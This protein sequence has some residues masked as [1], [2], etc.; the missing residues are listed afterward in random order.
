[1]RN[2][3][4]PKSHWLRFLLARKGAPPAISAAFMSETVADKEV[5][6]ASP[7]AFSSERLSR[8]EKKSSGREG[9]GGKGGV[10][11]GRLPARTAAPVLDNE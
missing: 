8:E 9:R 7:A 10:H 3:T 2:T 11:G 6:N 1:A 4:S 5:S